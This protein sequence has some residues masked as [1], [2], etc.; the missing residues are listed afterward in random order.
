[1][2]KTEK[3]YDFVTI[4]NIKYSGKDQ[5]DI[6]HSSNFTVA[7]QSDEKFTEKGFKL[8]WN[9]LTQ[10]EEWES[11]ADG[12]CREEMKLQPE[13]NGVDSNY[14][15]RYRKNNITCRKFNYIKYR[16]YCPFKMITFYYG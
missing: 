8:N 7:F 4:G 1:M 2:F 15:T 9:C 6:V 5:I 16:P 14:Q 3:K 10:W 13:Y 12:T 11:A